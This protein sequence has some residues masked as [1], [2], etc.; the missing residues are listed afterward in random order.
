MVRA[1]ALA[2]VSKET[3]RASKE[4]VDLRC[5]YRVASKHRLIPAASRIPRRLCPPWRI[6][7]AGQ[8]E[9][10]TA[11]FFLLGNGPGRQPANE[12]TQLA[13]VSPPRAGERKT[14][15]FP[16][17]FQTAFHFVPGAISILSARIS[18]APAVA[19]ETT[20]P[21]V[22]TLAC[23]SKNENH[24]LDQNLTEFYREKKLGRSSYYLPVLHRLVR[25]R[26]DSSRNREPP[27][28]TRRSFGSRAAQ[29]K[30]H[31]F[32][33]S[34]AVHRQELFCVVNSLKVL[35]LYSLFRVCSI[36]RLR[37]IPSAIML[38]EHCRIWMD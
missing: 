2:L 11:P 5:P 7:R 13:E 9:N 16:D 36:H 17:H 24:R 30:L 10:F 35:R 38:L 23:F 15:P 27:P 8:T 1:K 14:R 32:S 6:K 26:P 19:V 21:A 25:N 20:C 28:P 12:Q 4:A 22:S 34:A 37:L 31:H 3:D 18:T 33:H 29:A